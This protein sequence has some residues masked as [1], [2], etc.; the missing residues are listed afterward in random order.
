M[1]DHLGVSREL[2]QHENELVNARM[3]WFLTIQG[4]L[5]AGLAFAWNKGVA[6]SVVFSVVG[7]LTSFSIGI[8]LRYSTLA[9]KRIEESI[10]SEGDEHII[11]RSYKETPLFVHFLL[12]WH[13][14]PVVFFLAWASLIYIRVKGFA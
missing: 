3:G 13:F 2:I 5:F 9:I 14:L 4:F 6:L 11:G 1:A 8:L 10:S 7:V 12:P